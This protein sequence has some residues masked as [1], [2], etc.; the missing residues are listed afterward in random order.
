MRTFPEGGDGGGGGGVPP[1]MVQ[2]SMQRI[3]Y[4]TTLDNFVV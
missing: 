3:S 4:C 2:G 1:A